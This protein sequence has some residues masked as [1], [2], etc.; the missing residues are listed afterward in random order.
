MLTQ[1]QMAHYLIADGLTSAESIIDG[2]FEVI[3]ASRR[4]SNFKVVSDCGPSYFLKQLKEVSSGDTVANEARICRFLQDVSA[5]DDFLRYIPRVVKYD[6]D[7]GILVVELLRNARD[8]H[9]QCERS[10]RIPVSAAISL[11]R[12][13]SSLHRITS[14]ALDVAR[15]SAFLNHCPG[16]L[17]IH[18][19]SLGILRDTSSAN[20]QVIRIVQNTPGF[21]QSLDR[22]RDNWRVDSIIHND[23]KWDNCVILTR[24]G[25]RAHSNLKIVDWEFAGLGDSCWD[26]GAVFGAF[27]GS[28]I[29]SIPVSGDD[30]PARFLDLARYPLSRMHGPIRAFWSAYTQGREFDRAQSAEFLLRAVRYGAARLIQTAFEQMQRSSTLTGNVVCL[31]QLSFNILQRPHEAAAQLLGLPN[32]V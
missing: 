21:A 32:E 1:A 8:L 13:L 25:T 23:V 2:D 10:D 11:G 4:N 12:A 29:L 20:L 31:L 22:L 30:V 28:W 18:R 17:C 26:A 27:L 3:E 15:Q 24:E 5:D 16:V 6:S 14:A 7:H 9:E 19:P